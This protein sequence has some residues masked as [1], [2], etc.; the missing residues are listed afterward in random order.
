[1]AMPQSYDPVAIEQFI[2]ARIQERT[3]GHQAVLDQKIAQA[4]QV[5]DTNLN[6]AGIIMQQCQ[7][8]GVQCVAQIGILTHGAADALYFLFFADGRACARDAST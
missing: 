4:Q 6:Q 1:M 8:A 7:D 3:T 5:I 2:E